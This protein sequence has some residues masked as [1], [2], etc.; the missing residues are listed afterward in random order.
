MHDH[1]KL[2]ALA[3]GLLLPLV[4]GCKQ[5]E[6]VAPTSTA[7]AAIIPAPRE[8]TA[9]EGHFVVTQDTPV[10][11]ESGSGGEAAA[12]YF[13]DLMKRTRGFTL[14]SVPSNVSPA[15]G[16]IRFELTA[17]SRDGQEGYSLI[18]SPQRILVSAADS[19]GLFY[20]AVTLW[21]LMTSAAPQNNVYTIA[22]VKIE[23]APRFRWRGLMLDSARHFQ[24]P[25][26]VKQFID[27][28]ALHKLNV[29]H[30]H[31]TDDQ[32]WRLEIKKY[33]RLTSV[34][35]W[36]VP[37]GA[38]AAADIDPATGQPRRYGGFYSQ[39]EVKDIVAYAASRNIIIVPEIETPGHASAAIAAYPE[40]G[41]LGKSTAVPADWGIYP[42]L[43]N[44]DDS[45]FTFLENVLSEVI[46]LFPS[47]YI[48]VGGDEAVKDQWQA[49]P[50]IQA[51]M[52]ALGIK[53][54][55]ALQSYF[56]QRLEKF[57]SVHGRKL[58]G[59]DEILEGG[60][61]PN[62]TV[63]SWRGIDGA[64][65]A[66][67]AGHD[68]VL[69]PWP[70]LYFDNRQTNDT[71]PGRGRMITI[72]DV[73]AFDPAP[74]SIGPEQRKHILG[75]QANLWTEHM[76]TEDRVAYMAFPRA[77]ALAEVAWSPESK[78]NWPDFE[79]RLDVQLKRYEALGIR[80]AKTID[81]APLIGNRRTSHQLQLCTDKLVLSL[82]DD[83]PLLGPRATFWVDIMDPCWMYPAADLTGVRELRASVG[84][85]PFN[86]QIGKDVNAI[87]LPPPRTAS[88][89]LQVHLD[90][91][92]GALIAELP[93]APA[94]S[95]PEITPL[96]AVKI[97]DV[98]G[99][100]DLCFV[101]TRKSVDPTWVIDSIE[102]VKR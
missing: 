61:P 87:P 91:C 64:I 67:N 5:P 9:E 47:E 36:R 90:R 82:E 2:F 31:L 11:F 84:Q 74:K 43:Y 65:A 77:A 42:N 1:H 80:Y 14:R 23:D 71:Q 29:L 7:R 97:N 101:F 53:D 54:E 66:A 30:W 33:P 6:L 78:I 50:K 72:K 94:V 99:V 83:A 92:D 12:Q 16:V 26:F 46:A 52:R 62:A 69:S 85:V 37:A 22:A 40:L 8:L 35:A 76:R 15:K 73:Y 81:E 51:Q 39:E 27:C 24:S 45:T 18:A 38:A 89:E 75:V 95:N 28:M 70:T 96:P 10:S 32:A 88:G 56:I 60:L 93:L 59:W 63:M 98:S 49:S 21:Q 19:R 58:I 13:I 79:S 3:C 41:V 20:G 48:H 25:E 57:L 17:E 102:L 34:G 4:G 44:V 68:A 100:H 86:F 55:H